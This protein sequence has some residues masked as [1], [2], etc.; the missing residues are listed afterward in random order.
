MPREPEEYEQ[1]WAQ[2]VADLTTDDP[3]LAERLQVPGPSGPQPPTSSEE[4]RTEATDTDPQRP[5]EP[6]ATAP[7]TDHHDPGDHSRSDYTSSDYNPSD[8]EDEGHFVPP[9]PPELPA[10]TPATRLG[11]AGVIGG[12]VVMALSALTGW[13]PPAVVMWGAGAATVAGFITLVW[14]LPDSREDGWDEGA[15]L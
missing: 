7:H 6:G 2:I 9:H 10:G 14:Q 12:P 5:D 13:D 11:W 15:R 4:F 8:W 1:A 3:G